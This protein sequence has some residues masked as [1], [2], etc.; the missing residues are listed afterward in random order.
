MPSTLLLGILRGK[1]APGIIAPLAPL[2]AHIA[3]TRSSSPRAIPPSELAQ[4]VEAATGTTPEVFATAEDAVATLSKRGTTTVATG[5]I[6]LAGDVKRQ[7]R[8]V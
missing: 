6:T 1:D 3:V 2:F 5:S 7:S 4:I 8:A